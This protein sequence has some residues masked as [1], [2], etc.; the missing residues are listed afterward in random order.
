MYKLDKDSPISKEHR[1]AH[2]ACYGINA[3]C[4][5]GVI[6]GVP[7]L[8]SLLGALAPTFIAEPLCNAG[9]IFWFF[10]SPVIA[11]WSFTNIK[12]E[13]VRYDALTRQ[14]QKQNSIAAKIDIPLPGNS[15]LTDRT[16][17]NSDIEGSDGGRQ[18]ER[19]HQKTLEL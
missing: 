1:K 19:G 11:K 3:T 10:C 14:L 15:M 9:A 13:S 8:I 2:I 4:A 18:E 17:T 12:K 6:L 16:F 7:V 5:T